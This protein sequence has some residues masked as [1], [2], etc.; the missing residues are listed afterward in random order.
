VRL[1]TTAKNRQRGCRRDVRRQTVPNT[2]GSDRKSTIADGRQGV[3]EMT[4]THKMI[5]NTT[6]IC[7]AAATRPASPTPWAK[8]SGESLDL[9]TTCSRTNWPGC[10]E[11]HT[12]THCVQSRWQTYKITC[13]KLS[14]WKVWCRLHR[15]WQRCPT[16]WYHQSINQSIIKF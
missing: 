1:Q 7:S 14:C 4:H 2:C 9:F 12:K 13:K 3:H 8:I 10:A 6:W 16:R 15:L 11:A 5:N